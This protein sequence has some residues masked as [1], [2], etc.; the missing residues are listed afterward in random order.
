MPTYVLIL[1]LL[2]LSCLIRVSHIV[3]YNVCY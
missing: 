3:L 1:S 2:D